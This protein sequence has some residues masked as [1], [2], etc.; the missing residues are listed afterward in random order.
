[1]KKVKRKEIEMNTERVKI[2][3]EL[4]GKD[5]NEMLGFYAESHLDCEKCPLIDRCKK[6][7]ITCDILWRQFL[8]GE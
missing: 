7:L 4:T 2:L 6:T 8:E 3:E 1:M 5:I